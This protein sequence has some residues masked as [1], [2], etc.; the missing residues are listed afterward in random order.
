MEW[1]TMESAPRDG[2]PIILALELG[3]GR[4]VV[5]GGVFTFVGDR[6]PWVIADDWKAGINGVWATAEISAKAWMP[7]PNYPEPNALLSGNGK[8]KGTL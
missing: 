7:M 4:R 3:D 1:Q 2:R 8:Q 5:T 6:R